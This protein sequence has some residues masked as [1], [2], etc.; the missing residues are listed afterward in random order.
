VA[1]KRPRFSLIMIFDDPKL[2]IRKVLRRL[3]E[4]TINL[5]DKDLLLT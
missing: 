3:V 4:A 1:L 2:L 5:K